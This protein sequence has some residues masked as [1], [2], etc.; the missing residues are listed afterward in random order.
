MQLPSD[1][2]LDKFNLIDKLIY[3][4]D[5]T[6]CTETCPCNLYNTSPFQYAFSVEHYYRKWN[7]TISE[8]CAISFQT[9]P[10][11]TVKNVINDFEKTYSVELGK[12]SWNAEEIIDYL[13]KVEINVKCTGFYKASYYDHGNNLIFKYLFSDINRL[14]Y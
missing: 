9:C 6:L 4:V 5:D 13:A 11:V 2:I 12:Y 1:D 7:K 3:K 14:Y 8:N 10:K